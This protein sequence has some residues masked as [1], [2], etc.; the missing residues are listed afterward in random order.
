[1]C[2]CVFGPNSSESKLKHLSFLASRSSVSRY[3]ECDVSVQQCPSD[4]A[5][6]Q[7]LL[8]CHLVKHIMRHGQPLRIPSAVLSQRRTSGKRSP[9]RIAIMTHREHVAWGGVLIG[10]QWRR[11]IAGRPER[12]AVSKE[13]G[14]RMA[15][16]CTIH[17]TKS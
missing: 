7:H 4:G 10:G 2:L 1:M 9:H 17:P 3:R 12:D 16:S 13:S 11:G 8:L 5:L 14:E 15:E 6:A